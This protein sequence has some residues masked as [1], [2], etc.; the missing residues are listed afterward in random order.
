MTFK[1][2]FVKKQD[3]I[4]GISIADGWAGAVM[5]KKLAIQNVT[6]GPTGGQMDR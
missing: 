6:H 4:H 2:L 1:F 3:W 5:Q